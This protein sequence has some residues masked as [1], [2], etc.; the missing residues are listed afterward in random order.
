MT[1]EPTAEEHHAHSTRA[2]Q[3]RGPMWGCLKFVGCSTVSLF[4]LLV[5]IIGGGWWYLGSSSFEGLVR[6]RIEKTLEA[7]LDRKV[8]IGS[9]Q[10][11]RGQL[12]RI[13]ISDL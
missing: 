2:R 11:E 9:V 8:S 10:I 3:R 5:V 7:R 12:S 13:V 6:L 4:V 1:I